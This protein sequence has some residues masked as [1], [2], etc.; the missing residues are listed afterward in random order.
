[1]SLNYFAPVTMHPYQKTFEVLWADLDPNGHL[2]HT[3]YMDYGAQTRLAFL[4]DHGYTL[5]RMQAERIGPILFREDTRYLRE[6]RPN[7]R[8]TVSLA[9]SGLSANGKHWKI[10]HEIRR[11]D[12][13]LACV[14]DCQGAWLDL[15]ARRVTLPP[16]ALAEV[17]AR[18]PR[19]PDFEEIVS[20][21]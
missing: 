7:E 13:E 12:G 18:M 15:A 9:V 1:M 5:E 4:S 14:I 11:A 8:I 2:R 17:F 16:A 10:R 6:V 20:S 21:R 3:A 19:T